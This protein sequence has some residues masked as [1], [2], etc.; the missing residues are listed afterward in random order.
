ML[1]GRPGDNQGICTN[2][3]FK[4]NI[5]TCVFKGKI[6]KHAKQLMEFDPQI[7]LSRFFCYEIVS[8]FWFCKICVLEI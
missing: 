5:E 4:Q 1:R 6:S 8:I 7:I 2:S 3:D